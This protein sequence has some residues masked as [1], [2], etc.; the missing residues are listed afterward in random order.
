M[1]R[2]GWWDK[3]TGHVYT[4][5]SCKNDLKRFC[6]W[7]VLEHVVKHSDFET[8]MF[9][10]TGFLSGGRANE[11]LMLTKDNFEVKENWIDVIGMVVMKKFKR[12]KTLLN[13][14]WEED[15]IP[16]EWWEF[17]PIEVTIIKK[18]ALTRNFAIWRDE[19]LTQNL[20]DYLETLNKG[21]KLFK[22]KYDNA[23][24]LITNIQ[25]QKGQKSGPWFPHKLRGERATQLVVE[26]D[27]DVIKLQ[28]FFAW[29]D[30]ETPLDYVRLGVAGIKKSIL[31]GRERGE[32][33]N[34]KVKRIRIPAPLP[35]PKKEVKPKRKLT[36]REEYL[37]IG[38]D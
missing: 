31:G 34:K 29:E 25:K 38:E 30:P 27:F 7:N 24:R 1:T 37:G 16:N 12:I 35:P 2:K 11:I 23:Y 15:M 3:S 21:E 19:P 28:S 22:F 14:D 18:V 10:L 5:R 6:G 13:Y 17:D 36:M 32:F 20:V 26:Y 9:F 8:G 33:A 4:R